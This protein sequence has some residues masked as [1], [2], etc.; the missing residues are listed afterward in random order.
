M[1]N[2][3][4]YTKLGK[5]I[6]AR[7]TALFESP[8]KKA[9]L[10]WLKEKYYKHLPAGKIRTHSLFGK[11]VFFSN[12]SQFLEMLKEIFV[13]GIYSQSLP[14]QPYIIDCG[15]NIGLS[16]IYLKHNFPGAEIVAFEPDSAN[17]DLL[18]RNV[19]AMGFD[20]ITLRK[21]AVWKK[22]TVL[23]F[24]GR[25]STDSRIESES[26]SGSVEV[27]AVRLRDLLTRKVDF[28]KIDIEGAE[29]DV[30]KDLDGHLQQ[31]NNMFVEYHGTFEQ[32]DELVK[33]QDIFIRNGFQYYIRE[34]APIYPTPFNRTV[35]K[36]ILYDTQL[37]IFCFR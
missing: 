9:N 36:K 18:S 11:Y 21:E 19:H 30:L 37:N 1:Q 32:N 4:F 15:A 23:H 3:S 27:Q 24:S 12:P 31:V 20:H 35:N 26:N 28:L 17:F 8:A 13:E 10:T 34:A 16:V 33:L 25:G 29:I 5:G 22:N 6:K 14:D 7:T 2:N